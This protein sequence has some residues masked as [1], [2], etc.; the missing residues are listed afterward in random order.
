MKLNAALLANALFWLGVS[1]LPPLWIMTI[2]F[3]PGVVFYFGLMCWV[4]AFAVFK[5]ELNRDD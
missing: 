2:L 5:W 4:G 1:Q 3:I